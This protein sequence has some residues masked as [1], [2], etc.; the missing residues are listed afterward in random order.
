[1]PWRDFAIKL[2]AL[3]AGLFSAQPIRESLGWPDE[4][5]L[6]LAITL[7]VMILVHMALQRLFRPRR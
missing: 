6:T 4:M 1:M 3:A 2:A 7:P 5:V